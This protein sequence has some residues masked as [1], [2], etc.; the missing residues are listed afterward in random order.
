MTPVWRVALMLL[1][2]AAALLAITRYYATTL[3]A[4]A[5]E[6][7][8][9]GETVTAE[10]DI[11]WALRLNPLSFPAHQLM[12]RARLRAHD[13]Q[14]AVKVAE[15]TVRIAPSDPNSLYLAGETSAAA[16]RWDLAEDRFRSAVDRASLSQLRFHA[17]LVE[18]SARVGKV[19]DARWRYEQAVSLFTPE[20]VLAMEARCLAPGDRY[21]LARMNRIAARLYAE[22]GDGARSQSVLGQARRLAE[23]DPRG[24]CASKGRPGQ[25]SPE[26][27]AA[28]FWH[29][30]S[31]G[32]WLLAERLLVP[33][34]RRAA[35]DI[36]TIEWE[37]GES[38]HRTLL[39]WV[40]AL[41]GGERK[42]NL[43]S[44]VEV[45]FGNGRKVLRCTQMDLRL[46]GDGWFIERLP[47]LESGPCEP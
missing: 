12:A 19:A 20:R 34:L 11:T 5:Q 38:P 10:R 21:L 44:E 30:L 46:I 14:G 29:A 1:L 35:S 37:K 17:S 16:G 39:V 41:S 18:A 4:G 6:A 33:E 25:T 32:G 40:T 26:A 13:V 7:L 22:T 45:E 2:A 24:I 28:S 43:R 31:E 47:R 3:T 9:A 15:R 42:A 36:A 23:P 27:A 8:A